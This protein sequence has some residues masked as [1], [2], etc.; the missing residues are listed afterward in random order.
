MAWTE[1]P[2]VPAMLNRR[3]VWTV[4]GLVYECRLIYVGCTQNPRERLSN[5]RT[6][7][8]PHHDVRMV[9][10]ATFECRREA[11][12]TEELLIDVLSPEC[13][14]IGGSP[15]WWKGELADA[16]GLPSIT[17]EAAAKHGYKSVTTLNNH[18]PGERNKVLIAAGLKKAPEQE[19]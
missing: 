6:V 18:F 4:Y 7:N 19:T 3:D 9:V 8:F 5:H 17:P 14:A 12:G 15:K 2:M 1:K 11:L 13:N 10:F 16:L